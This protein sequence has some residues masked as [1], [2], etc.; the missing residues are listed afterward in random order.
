MHFF[1]PVPVMP[2]VELI[3]GARTTTRPGGHPAIT[4]DLGKQLIVSA[5]DRASSSTAS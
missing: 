3:R 5:T 1:S 4:A 2:L